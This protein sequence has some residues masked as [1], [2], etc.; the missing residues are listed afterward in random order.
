MKFAIVLYSYFPYGGLQQDLLKILQACRR[1]Q[2]TVTVFC[3][4]WEGEKPI[5]TDIV[6][7]PSQG[8]TKTAKRD[9]FV[10]KMLEATLDKYDLVLGFNKMPGLDYYYAADYCFAEKAHVMKGLFYTG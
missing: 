3:M 1:K 5:N 8:Y 7:L 4:E 9:Y 10:E 2:I 6:I